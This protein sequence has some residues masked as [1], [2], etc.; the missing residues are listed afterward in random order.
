MD[1]ALTLIY[2]GVLDGN[3]NAVTSGVQQ[4]LGAGVPAETLLNT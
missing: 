2:Q 3:V 4:A 1:Q